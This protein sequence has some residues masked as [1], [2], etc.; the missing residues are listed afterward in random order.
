M[1]IALS[2]AQ[3]SAARAEHAKINLEVSAA[4]E[5]V[6]AYVDQTPPEWGKNPRPV[7]K[8]KVKDRI[9]VEYMLTNV[10]PH[11]TLEN[12]VVHFYIVRQKK[13]GQKELPDL[14]G[15]VV[16]ETAFDMDFKP[17]GKA[18]QRSTLKIESPGAYLIRVETRNTQSDHEHF[19]AVDL[20]VE[21]AKPQPLPAAPSR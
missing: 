15:D 20:L 8:A 16:C 12:V 3:G 21:E 4:G 10:Y 9:R 6:A 18:K 13:V 2:A 1:G 17:G 11:K 14:K 7:L 5:S 19:A